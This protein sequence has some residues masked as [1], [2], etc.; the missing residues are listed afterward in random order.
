[1][2]R[3]RARR[4]RRRD[5]RTAA[6]SRGAWYPMH[7]WR[8][9]TRS[10]SSRRW[11]SC[12]AT[13]TAA[14]STSRRFGTAARCSSA[15]RR[16]RRRSASG[17]TWTRG[18]AD[19]ARSERPRTRRRLSLGETWHRLNVEQRVAAV[20]A[21]LLIVSTLGPFSFVEAAI[22]L[23]GASVLLLLRRRSEGREFHIPFGDGAVIAAAGGW[24]AILILV[25]LF[26]RPLGQGLLALVCAATLI[27]A[28]LRERSKHPPDDLPE[29]REA[30][31][32]R[33]PDEP[34]AGLPPR[35]QPVPDP[36]VYRDATL[37]LRADR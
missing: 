33:D 26:S 27:L 37:P 22:V 8:C 16:A 10:S 9:G 4:C 3:R 17:T 31:G 15:G 28:G 24:A 6:A 13:W 20:G 23:I 32:P 18:M 19:A 36:A 1:M 14:S 25:R 34:F 12:S 11:R 30:D 5:R 7:S 21:L 29:R 2:T 35:T